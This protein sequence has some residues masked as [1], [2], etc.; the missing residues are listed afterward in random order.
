LTKGW[1]A[2]A[3]YALTSGAVVVAGAG[4]LSL[5]LTPA[6]ARALWLAG[7]LAYGVQIVAFGALVLLRELRQGFLLAWVGGVLLRFGVV[8]GGGFWLVQSAGQPPLPLLLGLA[9]FVFALLLLEPVF[10]RWAPE[11]ASR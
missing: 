8:L 6:A 11:S 1:Q 9:G 10:F 7:A 5:L 3:A 4:F 2:L